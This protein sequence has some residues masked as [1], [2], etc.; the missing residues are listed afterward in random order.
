MTPDNEKKLL[1]ERTNM[2]FCIEHLIAAQLRISKGD[3]QKQDEE[4]KGLTDKL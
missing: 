1:K 4:E 3:G 2:K